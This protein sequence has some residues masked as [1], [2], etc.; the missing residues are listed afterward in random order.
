MLKREYWACTGIIALAFLGILA[1]AELEKDTNLITGNFAIPKDQL[2]SRFIPLTF[3][4]VVITTLIIFL[5]VYMASKR[6]N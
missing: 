5:L 2:A 1:V 6:N 4:L 3:S